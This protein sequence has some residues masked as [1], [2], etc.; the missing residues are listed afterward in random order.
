VAQGQAVGRCRVVRR[1]EVAM[2][3]AMLI[4]CVRSVAVVALA[5]TVEARLPVARVRLNA[6]AARTSHAELAANDAEGM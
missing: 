5:W 6:I 1:P 2:R 3:A 4:S